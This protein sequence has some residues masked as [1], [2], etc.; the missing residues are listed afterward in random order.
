VRLEV[1][2]LGLLTGGH[3][4]DARKLIPE[5]RVARDPELID[6]VT[7]IFVDRIEGLCY[8]SSS[9]LMRGVF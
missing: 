2:L 3:N 9:L 7:N 5:K 1:W 8:E 4:S 6:Y